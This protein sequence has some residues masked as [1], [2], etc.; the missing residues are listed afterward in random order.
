MVATD[1]IGV[2]DYDSDPA[3]LVRRHLS[4]VSS[5]ELLKHGMPWGWLTPRSAQ[6]GPPQPIML[7]EFGGI[8]YAAD[9]EKTWGYSRC[10]TVDDLALR[11]G[12]LLAAVHSLPRLAGFCYT[13]FAD[14]YQETNGL[15]GEDRRPK[16][17][18]AEIAAATMGD[19]MEPAAP[20]RR[21]VGSGRAS[22]GDLE[23][24]G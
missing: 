9:P 17:A 7:T 18:L 1:I 20:A 15:L 12:E 6:G 13:Q 4:E 2:H 10:E 11:Y 14:T 19:A 5:P 23:A 22:A 21:W 8:A 3:R 16:F 24:A